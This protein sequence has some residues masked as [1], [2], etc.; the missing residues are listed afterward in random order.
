MSHR[1]IS[2][3]KNL[4]LKKPSHQGFTLIELAITLAVVATL[5]CLAVPSFQ[6]LLETRRIE[7]AVNAVAS[8][9]QRARLEALVR[10]QAV[11]LSFHQDAAGSCYVLHTGPGTHCTCLT[12]GPS[13]GA[14]TCANSPTVQHI[15]TAWYPA[16]ERLTVAANVASMLFDPL[17]GTNTPAATVKVASPNGQEVRHV[18]NLM[19]RGRSCAVKTAVAG[20][21][22]C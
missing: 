11:R 20:Y 1:K 17:H 10:H 9:V 12:Q 19:G 4:T 14:N 18:V 15:K 7:S 2:P 8:D 3:Q 6:T 13:V 22:L 21:P 5:L 16:A